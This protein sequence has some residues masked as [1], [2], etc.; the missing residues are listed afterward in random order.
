MATRSTDNQPLALKTFIPYKACWELCPTICYE[1]RRLS[2]L[3]PVLFT[4][5][6]S[7]FDD[8]VIT[9]AAENFIIIAPGLLQPGDP[10]LHTD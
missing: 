4:P 6:F 1:P 10:V 8:D 2:I 5:P 7:S 3:A 9:C